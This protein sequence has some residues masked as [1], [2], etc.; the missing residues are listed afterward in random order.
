MDVGM[1]FGQVV[2]KNLPGTRWDQVLKNKKDADYGQPVIMGFGAAPLNPVWILVTTA[3][4]VSRKKAA[5]LRELYE[6]W[7]KMRK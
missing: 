7:A 1:Y 3:Y 4:G 6:T 5:R 2:L